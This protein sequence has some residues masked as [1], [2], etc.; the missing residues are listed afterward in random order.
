[1]LA[2]EISLARQEIGHDHERI[3]QSDE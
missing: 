1:L 2:E 3:P